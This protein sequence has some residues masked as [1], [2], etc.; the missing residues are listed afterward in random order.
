MINKQ[1]NTSLWLILEKLVSLTISLCV[2]VILAQYLNVNDFGEYAYYLAFVSFLIPFFSLGLNSLVTKEVLFQ[3]LARSVIVNTLFLRLIMGF[4]IVFII[5]VIDIYFTD[6]KYEVEFHILLF[7]I[8]LT[9]GQ[10][11]DF[12]F[13]AFEQNKYAIFIRTSVLVSGAIAKF[14]G[15]YYELILTDFLLIIAMEYVATNIGLFVLFKS[16][17]PL[18]AQLSFNRLYCI[19]VLKRSFWLYLSSICAVLYLKLDQIMLRQLVNPTEVAHYAVAAKFTEVFYFIPIA[20]MTAYFPKIIH[21]ARDN[22]AQYQFHLSR[23]STFLFWGSVSLVVAVLLVSQYLVDWF[24]TDDYVVS[25]S[26]IS[27]H[28]WSLIFVFQRALLSKW[29]LVEKLF[30]F[31]LIS[32]GSGAV[33]NIILNFWWIPLYG[34]IGAAWATVF[35]H[36]VSST[37]VLVLFSETRTMFMLQLTS[38]YRPIMS[39]VVRFSNKKH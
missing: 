15:I 8:V 30:R 13:Q 36:M 32:Q 37:L 6:L 7:C 10:V 18:Y 19:D 20:I 34:G 11:F 4:L 22:S 5:V 29:L 3:P 14:L 2:F 38:I 1:R 12:G 23:L 35:S 27:I 24:F 33:L 21:A 28:V 9:A 39:G 16:K 26:I 17:N 31:S 25:I